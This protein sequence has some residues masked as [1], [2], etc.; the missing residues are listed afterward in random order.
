M[1]YLH[2]FCEYSHSNN[3]R[4]LRWKQHIY[5]LWSSSCS[6][7]IC[8]VAG[9]TAWQCSE[10]KS[11]CNSIN[12]IILWPAER[13]WAALCCTGSVKKY[14]Q[15]SL[16]PGGYKPHKGEKTTPP[17]PEILPS[18][19]GGV[20]MAVLPSLHLSRLPSLSLS[21]SITFFFCISLL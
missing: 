2:C 6:S 4:W 3:W 20:T 11:I 19:T 5:Q 17:V 15:A 12:N 1:V 8:V 14:P 21:S 13:R 10:R 9:W 16:Y 7:F 18:Q